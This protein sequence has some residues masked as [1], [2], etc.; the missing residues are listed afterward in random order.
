MLFSNIILNNFKKEKDRI[1]MK[2]KCFD[3]FLLYEI[4]NYGFF[5]IFDK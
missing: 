4:G 2:W 1:E 5:W 3:K